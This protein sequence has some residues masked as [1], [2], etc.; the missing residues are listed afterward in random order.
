MEWAGALVLIIAG[1]ILYVKLRR[2]ADG[3]VLVN[4]AHTR[5]DREDL[6]KAKKLI[7]KAERYGAERGKLEELTLRFNRVRDEIRTKRKDRGG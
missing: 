4:R 6:K 5:L 2:R 3:Q 7:K 1:F